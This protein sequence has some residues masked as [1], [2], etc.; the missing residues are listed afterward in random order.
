[1]SNRIQAVILANDEYI[2]NPENGDDHT[3]SSKRT[4]FA[5]FL[6]LIK[7]VQKYVDKVGEC[8]E[9]A[10][11]NIR[12]CS[13]LL[14][15]VNNA[16]GEV[17]I[18]RFVKV[19]EQI[20]N[21]VIDVSQLQG[22]KALTRASKGRLYFGRPKTD[23]NIEDEEAINLDIRDMKNTDKRF[24][25][26][27]GT[28]ATL[29]KTFQRK[30]NI[31]LFDEILDDA[32]LNI[33]HFQ[34]T[35]VF[36]KV[37]YTAPEKLKDNKYP[38]D[39]SLL[40]EIAEQRIPFQSIENDIVEIRQRVLENKREQ[41]SLPL[42]VPFEWAYIVNKAL[43]TIFMELFDF[44]EKHLQHLP[45]TQHPNTHLPWEIPMP[46][47]GLDITC[48]NIQETAEQRENARK[49][50]A[51]LFKE[52][53]DMDLPEAQLRYGHCLWKGEGV[54]KKWIIGCGIF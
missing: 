43:A 35:G 22:V 26:G 6:P 15:R 4:D 2:I 9:N 49:R 52:T 18:L 41:F 42:Q 28:I 10:E 30:E 12:V 34:Y 46:N 23:Q 13:V 47:I 33:Q 36:D 11:Y 14:K 3:E 44:S 1:M 31:V 21:F 50:A 5:M 25:E 27:V 48:L 17:K 38:Y 40:W 20:Q 19:I 7:D 51:Q 45:A 32:V 8:Y 53:A 54:E 39:L 29:N 24:L 37:R 16:G